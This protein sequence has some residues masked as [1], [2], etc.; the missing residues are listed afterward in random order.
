MIRSIAECSNAIFSCPRIYPCVEGVLEWSIEQ[1]VTSKTPIGHIHLSAKC[2][3]PYNYT[4]SPNSI[5]KPD[6][7]YLACDQ[8]PEDRDCKLVKSIHTKFAED[9]VKNILVRSV[10]K[11]L[12]VYNIDQAYL[13]PNDL[14]LSIN[15]FF[16]DEI[17]SR[18]DENSIACNPVLQYHEL[19][20]KDRGGGGVPSN[21]ILREAAVIHGSYEYSVEEGS[22]LQS[23]VHELTV[24]FTPSNTKKY[25]QVAKTI[26][27]NVHKYRPVLRWSKYPIILNTNVAISRADVSAVC[28]ND[29]SDEDGF[30]V[31]T[32]PIGGYYSEPGWCVRLIECNLFVRYKH[33]QFRKHF[34]SHTFKHTHTHT[35]THA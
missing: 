35:H 6:A 11:S 34:I 10:W 24:L 18:S 25:F 17:F 27:L 30:V 3:E 16:V 12:R 4:S 5:S 31:Y 20:S 22:I 9:F 8:I 14:N 33:P 32:P 1:H 21:Q 7:I 2:L 26:I 15:R 28:V 29:C 19:S 13:D 23:G